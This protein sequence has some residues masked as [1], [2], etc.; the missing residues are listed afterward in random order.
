MKGLQKRGF[1]PI[2]KEVLEE[3]SPPPL[4]TLSQE[5]H[6][7]RVAAGSCIYKGVAS[8]SAFS[9]CTSFCSL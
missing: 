3:A 5:G 6:M 9:S 1:A 7:V 8:F 4:P 2:V